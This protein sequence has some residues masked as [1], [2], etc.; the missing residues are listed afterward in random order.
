MFIYSDTA[1]ICGREGCNNP[2]KLNKPTRPG[3]Y[4]RFC[5]AKCSANSAS[6]RKK[7]EDSC[8]EKYGVIS[9]LQDTEIKKKS[10]AK[11]IEKYGVEY[12]LQSEV[13]RNRARE[14]NIKKYGVDN[15]AKSDEIYNKVKATNL[16]K[17]GSESS[18]TNEDVR[19]KSKQTMM[20]RYGVEYPCQNHEIFQKQQRGKWKIY[21]FPSGE[22]V[23]IQGYEKYALDKLLEIYDED[24]ICLNFDIP[25]IWY[26]YNGKKKKYIPDIFVKSKNLIVE[27]KSEYTYKC[28]LDRNK[29]KEKATLDNGYNFQFMIFNNKKELV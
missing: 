22:E 6:T 28:D 27:V 21:K 9:P 19:K 13:F 8:I 17:Y 20:D 4:N 7:R 14:T 29:S 18:F 15:P 5:S 12:P 25:D 3:V 11:M 23:K 26:N 24:D 1:P 16:E 10:L 2:S